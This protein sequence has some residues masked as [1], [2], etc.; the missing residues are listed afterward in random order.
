MQVRTKLTARQDGGVR[1]CDRSVL[2]SPF[3]VLT[4]IHAPT[5]PLQ[6]WPRA[7]KKEWSA[8][9]EEN[10]IAEYRSKHWLR[11][12]QVICEDTPSTWED[13]S[14]VVAWMSGPVTACY[15]FNSRRQYHNADAPWFAGFEPFLHARSSP[16]RPTSRTAATF[17]APSPSP[18]ICRVS[19]SASEEKTTLGN[20]EALAGKV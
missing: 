20:V 12:S 11:A 6:A 15:E 8:Y 17:P 3:G 14:K 19:C 5:F 18:T 16:R 4:R 13:G 7:I 10:L 1:D 2:V 9:S